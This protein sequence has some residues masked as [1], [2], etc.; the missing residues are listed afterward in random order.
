VATFDWI[1]LGV[2][3]IS[4]LVGAWRGLVYEVLS[5]L[6]WVA[7]FFLA[8][9]FAPAL[10]PSL[11]MSGSPEPLRYAAAFVLVFVGVAF[12][13]GLLVWLIKKMVEAVGLRPIDRSLGAVFGL[14]RGVVLLLAAAVVVGMSPMKNAAWWGESTAAPLLVAALKNLKPVLPQEFAKYIAS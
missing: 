7:A 9:M 1:A 6:T 4:M 2:L 10:A 13:T 11:P 3:L 5:V 8:Q 12:A 14:L